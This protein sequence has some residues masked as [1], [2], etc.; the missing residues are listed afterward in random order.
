MTCA[1]TP[2]ERCMTESTMNSRDLLASAPSL[3]PGLVPTEPANARTYVPL[4]RDHLTFGECADWLRLSQR[5][6]ARLL[7]TGVGPPVIRISE[8][9]LIFRKRDLQQWLAERTSGN[10]EYS[11]AGRRRGRR[12]V[13]APSPEAT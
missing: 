6:L 12:S 10:R 13:T 1:V 11:K 7:E 4:E 3:G 2:R 9:R 8:R 5:T